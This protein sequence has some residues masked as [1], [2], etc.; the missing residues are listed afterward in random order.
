MVTKHMSVS[1]VGPMNKRDGPARLE[2]KAFL[3]VCEMVTG[4]GIKWGS[5]LH[6]EF[7][8]GRNSCH[9]EL[10]RVEAECVLVRHKLASLPVPFILEL[11][12]PHAVREFTQMIA[13]YE[14]NIEDHL[15]TM[16]YDRQS[17][18]DICA[19]MLKSVLLPCMSICTLK[20]TDSDF[21]QGLLIKL[22]CVIPN[23]KALILPPV[24]SPSYL[25]LLVERIQILTCLQR[26]DFYVGCTTEILIE[27]SKYC[28]QMKTIS[29]QH[30][31][32]VDDSC[33]QHL[34]KLRQLVFL[35][36]TDTSVSANGY[37]ALLL[38]LS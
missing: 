36:I 12:V 8:T 6:S 14:N 22:L 23:I 35:D 30:S 29:V 15:V 32:G 19:N 5:R 38:G 18:E 33:V 25:Q 13:S 37:R 26:F 27:L 24:Q 9:R 16:L 34:L 10:Q 7:A 4:V 17:Y 31:R 1:A 20:I 21:V 11:I 28:L 2:D 3:Q